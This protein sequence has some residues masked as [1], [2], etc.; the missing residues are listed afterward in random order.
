MAEHLALPLRVLS[1]G[2]L[3]TVEQDSVDDVLQCVRVVLGT[4]QGTRD[5]LP[6]FGLPDLTFSEGGADVAVIEETL[7]EWEPR[8]D[9]QARHDDARL[10]EGVSRVVVEVLG[11]GF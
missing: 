2:H 1:T 6:E 8:A 11:G 3:A 7:S 4:P 9:A 10:E 5:E